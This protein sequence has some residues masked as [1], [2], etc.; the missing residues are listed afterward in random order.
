MPTAAPAPARTI[1][2]EVHFDRKV[3]RVPRRT[4]PL[5]LLIISATLA[6]LLVTAAALVSLSFRSH[7]RTVEDLTDHALRSATQRV[8]VRV[9]RLISQAQRIGDRYHAW[10]TSGKLS[11][12]N[13]Q[14][15]EPWLFTRWS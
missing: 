2:I 11:L 3:H 14:Q 10:A 1:T 6:P 9:G 8:E 13:L 15:W 7:I 12:S 4:V 5:R